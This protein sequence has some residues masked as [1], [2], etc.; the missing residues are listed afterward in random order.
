M[1]DPVQQRGGGNLLLGAGEGAVPGRGV[2]EDRRQGEHVARLRRP[3]AGGLFR[4]EVAGGT[5]D[6]TDT[7]ELRVVGG[8]GH[9]EI[10]QPRPVARQEDV[11]RLEVPVCQARAVHGLHRAAQLGGQGQ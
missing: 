10:D 7:G 3:G 11:A 6:T 2:N 4:R 9:P 8:P 5:D 1:D